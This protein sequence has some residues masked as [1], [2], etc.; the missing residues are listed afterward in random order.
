MIMKDCGKPEQ[1]R[2]KHLRL[3]TEFG[4][5]PAGTV[6]EADICPECGI[7]VIAEQLGLDDQGFYLIHALLAEI[8][9][10]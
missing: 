9:E 8:I 5:V 2:K 6:V 10:E 3:R 1:H 7:F 4:Q